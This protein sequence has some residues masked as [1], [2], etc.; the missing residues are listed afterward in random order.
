MLLIVDEIDMSLHTRACEAIFQLFTDPRI[1]TQGAQIIATTHDTNLIC[2][3][4]LGRD[5]I[6]FAEKNANGATEIYP[7]SDFKVRENDNFERGYLRGRFGALP[8]AGDPA[9]LFGSM[10]VNDD[11]KV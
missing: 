3:P 6:W 4:Q 1:N 9:E 2:S 10:R 7:L 8:F 11:E 5:Q